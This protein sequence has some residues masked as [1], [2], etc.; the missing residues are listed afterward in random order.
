MSTKMTREEREA[1]LADL[2]VGVLGVNHGDIPLAVP[3][4]YDYEPGGDVWLLTSPE[5][6]K[7]KGLE[8]TGQFSL[9][10]QTETPPYK[11]VTV[12][13]TLREVEDS[14]PEAS[15]HMAYRYLG[16]EFGDMYL[17]ANANREGSSKFYRL[18]PERWY[19]ADYGKAF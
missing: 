11:Y 2:H 13:G 12:A 15:K 17:A 16:P 5:S 7:G 8:A 9:C 6:I 10:A 18:T 14:T 4:W 19:T 1:F 3:I